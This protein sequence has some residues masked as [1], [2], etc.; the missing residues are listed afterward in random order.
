[1]DGAPGGWFELLF[2]KIAGSDFSRPKGA[3]RAAYKDVG[4][5]LSSTKVRDY[6][7]CWND[8]QRDKSTRESGFFYGWRAWR[9]VRTPVRQI[10]LVPMREQLNLQGAYLNV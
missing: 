4:C 5:N 2:E 6:S 9:L 3:R 7:V 8:E 1:M 10:F